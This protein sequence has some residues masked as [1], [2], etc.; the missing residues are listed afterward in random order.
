[1]EMVGGG[2]DGLGGS[3][4]EVG[5]PL[6]PGET[7]F[8]NPALSPAFGAHVHLGGQHL[9]QVTQVR[10]VRTLGHLGQAHA[11]G[12]HRRQVELSRRRPD[13]GLRCCVGH[14]GHQPTPRRSS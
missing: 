3:Q 4:V 6:D 13:G 14:L 5:Q 8:M 9:G 10:R 11:L 12:A 7:G 2:I 1:M